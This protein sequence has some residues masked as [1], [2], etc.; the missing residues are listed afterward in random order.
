MLRTA[1]KHGI[2]VLITLALCVGG[3]FL[4]NE[5]VRPQYEAAASLVATISSSESGTYNE[6]LASQMLTKTYEDAIQS[7]FV[8]NEAKAKLQTSESAYGLLKRIKVRT[9]PG[10]LVLVLYARHDN[11]EDAVAI[12]NAFAESFISKSTE[13]VQS[14][15]VT[16]LDYANLE[17]ASIPVSPK[18]LFNLAI[19]IFI[20]VF[21]SLSVAMLLEKRDASRRKRRRRGNPEASD[22][23]A[24]PSLATDQDQEKGTPNRNEE[25]V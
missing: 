11:P 5:L 22:P 3:V 17:D 8:A 4:A 2:A 15:N 14:A 13:I 6:F 19:G 10:T 9:D 25:A 12:A 20:G 1:K 16:V 24:A 18:K 21:A 23:G 7:R